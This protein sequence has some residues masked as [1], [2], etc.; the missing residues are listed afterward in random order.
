MCRVGFVQPKEKSKTLEGPNCPLPP[1]EGRE[2]TARLFLHMYHE[3]RE[4]SK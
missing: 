3:R 2:E 4:G 1:S